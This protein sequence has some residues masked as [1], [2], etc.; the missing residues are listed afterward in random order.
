MTLNQFFFYF[1][2]HG[3][4]QTSVKQFS[5]RTPAGYKRLPSRHYAL[6]GSYSTGNSGVHFL[7]EQIYGSCRVK[8]MLLRWTLSF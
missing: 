2:K 6:G 1:F 7:E 3:F 8:M 4:V 5:S